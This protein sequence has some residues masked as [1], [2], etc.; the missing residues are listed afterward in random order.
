MEWHVYVDGAS[1]GNPGESG[2]G[3]IAFNEKGQELFRD[4]IYL[5][6]MT[7]NMAEYEALVHALK[8]AYQASVKNLFVYTDSLLVANQITGKY[9]IKNQGLMKYA[10]TAKF[11]IKSFNN[12]T[13]QYIPRQ[14]NT[15]A[16]K[17]A[18]EAV[19]YKGVD[20]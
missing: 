14:K 8:K 18:K 16:D 1:S 7:N 10:E 2:A 6:H 15:L 17:L 3:V 11:I 9:K 19:Y 12:F 20:R 13:L 5:G 4:S